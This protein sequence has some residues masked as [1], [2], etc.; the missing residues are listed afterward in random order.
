MF[1]LDFV[2]VKAHILWIPFCFHVSSLRISNTV[3]KQRKRLYSQRQSEFKE[4]TSVD[5]HNYRQMLNM[6]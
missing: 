2:V 3:L 4:I 6:I 5:G 1:A